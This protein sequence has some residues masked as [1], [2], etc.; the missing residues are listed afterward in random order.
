MS[1]LRIASSDECPLLG[2]PHRELM[3]RG[4]SLRSLSFFNP[5]RVSDLVLV[6]TVDTNY[7]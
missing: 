5:A 7:C 6:L 4:C 2:G 1:E 3:E